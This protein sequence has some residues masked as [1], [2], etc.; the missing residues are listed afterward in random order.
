LAVEIG[1]GGARKSSTARFT[2]ETLDPFRIVFSLKLTV[3]DH[4]FWGSTGEVDTCSFHG[5]EIAKSAPAVSELR[6]QL[7]R[8]LIA[9]PKIN[10]GVIRKR[11]SE[12]DTIVVGQLEPIINLDISTFILLR[13]I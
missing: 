2:S 5:D 9:T 4:I 11:S 8:Y 10:Y 13:Y 7:I 1:E 6:Y 12:L 3:S